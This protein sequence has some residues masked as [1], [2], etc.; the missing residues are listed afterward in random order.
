MVVEKKTYKDISN[1]RNMFWNYHSLILIW[2]SCTVHMWKH[3]RYLMSPGC[4][5]SVQA[6]VWTDS[7]G[8]WAVRESGGKSG[9]VDQG[10]PQVLYPWVAK[11]QQPRL[12]GPGIWAAPVPGCFRERR[13]LPQRLPGRRW[14]REGSV[15]TAGC[16]LFPEVFCGPRRGWRY[17]FSDLR[18]RGLSAGNLLDA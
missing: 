12:P 6:A 17:L 10:V 3:R 9:A 16:R 1:Q 5:L 7:W 15:M 18:G 2:Y 4:P 13:P 8:H 14:G 11:Q